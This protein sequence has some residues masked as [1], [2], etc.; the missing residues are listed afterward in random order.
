[1]LSSVV[2]VGVIFY[3]GR[4]LKNHW[5]GF[6]AGLSFLLTNHI[7]RLSR[8]CRMDL[9]VSLF[10]TLAVLSFILAQR[11]SRL[12]YLLF[13]L[14]TCLAIF[15]KD[16]AGLAPLVIVFIY[17][18]ISWQWKKIISS[19]IHIRATLSY[20]PGGSMDLV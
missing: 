1:M 9:P 16:V 2:L 3:L 10:I 18:A 7:V 8:Q 5:V 14:S 19:L 20:R 17:L 11:R 15:S 6:F 13:G 12:Y 4:L